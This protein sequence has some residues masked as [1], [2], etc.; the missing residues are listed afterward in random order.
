MIKMKN[1]HDSEIKKQ[2]TFFFA[3]LIIWHGLRKVIEKFFKGWRLSAKIPFTSSCFLQCTNFMINFLSSSNTYF[4]FL[5]FS[6]YRIKQNHI[7]QKFLHPK[8]DQLIFSCSKIKS[9][10]N[11]FKE[12]DFE[13]LPS[14]RKE[15]F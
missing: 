13:K 8:F 15:F 14:S 4:W 12:W 3:I 9:S 6:L 2:I 1:L 11:I 10:E 5:H 7:E